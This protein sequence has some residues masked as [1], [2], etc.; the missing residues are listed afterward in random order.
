MVC[1]HIYSRKFNYFIL[2]LFYLFEFE[3]RT[4]LSVAELAL[5]IR[6]GRYSYKSNIKKFLKKIYYEIYFMSIHA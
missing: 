2:N 4:T 1:I 3:R 5:K 6:G